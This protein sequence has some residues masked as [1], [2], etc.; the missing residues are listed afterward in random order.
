MGAQVSSAQALKIGYVDD[1]Q[2]IKEYKAWQRA[3]EDWDLEYKAWQEEAQQKQIEIQDLFSEY[4][5]QKLILSDEKRK[6]KEAT[7]RTKEEDLDAFT[8]R[9]FGP[10]GKAEKKQEQLTLPL[11]DNV[12]KAI[13]A[14]AVEGNYDVIFTVAGSGL[15]YIKETYDITAKVI[16]H[17]ENVE[18]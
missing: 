9:I 4:E 18:Q 1:Q 12:T 6:E 15:G 14:I 8:R 7:I 13:E 10:G 17:L 11:L 5:K 16:E 2:I 3:Q